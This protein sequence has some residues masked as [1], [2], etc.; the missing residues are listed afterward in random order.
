[1]ERLWSVVGQDTDARIGGADSAI[2]R[3]SSRSVRAAGQGRA[4]PGRAGQG[5][6]GPGRAGQ[7]RG[8]WVEDGW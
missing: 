2:D 3:L 7:G 1:M 4:G 6:A 5:R 8:G